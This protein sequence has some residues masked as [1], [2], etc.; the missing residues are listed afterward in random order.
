MRCSPRTFSN[1][2]ETT[3]RSTTSFSNVRLD[4]WTR[5][6]T[7]VGANAETLCVTP[8]VNPRGKL[9]LSAYIGQFTKGLG[10]TGN[11]W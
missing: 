1:E 4:C 3:V 8:W 10:Y 6:V 2:R 9:Q 7:K 11:T 5:G